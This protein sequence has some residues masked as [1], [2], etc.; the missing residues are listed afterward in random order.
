M[1]TR[2]TDAV[3]KICDE[4]E[5]RPEKRV[6][7]SER[8]RILPP[9][10]R[11]GAQLK[12]APHHRDSGA[13]A[14]EESHRRE[15]VRNLVNDSARDRDG[16]FEAIVDHYFKIDCAIFTPN[17]ERLAHIIAMAKQYQADGVI[18]YALQFCSPYTVESYGVE[19]ALTGQGIPVLRVETD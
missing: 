10:A 17:P 13:V 1:T 5:T 19:K 3:N 18:H 15:G 6:V 8:W 14:G 12:A 2:F 16:L 4:L 9:A 7:A 11:C